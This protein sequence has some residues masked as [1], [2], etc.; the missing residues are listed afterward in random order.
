MKENLE[1]L[2]IESFPFG[3]EDYLLLEEIDRDEFRRFVEG[4]I[5]YIREIG[6]S[7]Q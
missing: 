3:S 5:G 7:L 6:C 1:L 4:F 2:S